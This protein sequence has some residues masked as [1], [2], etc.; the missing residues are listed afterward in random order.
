MARRR[1]SSVSRAWRPLGGLLG[2]AVGDASQSLG[3]LA[4]S[5][6]T[7][8]IT[9]FTFAAITNTLEDFPGLLLFIPAAIGLRGNVF[10]PLGS[11]LSTAIRTGTFAWS[12]RHDSLLGQNVIGAMAGSLAAAVGLAVVADVVANWLRSGSVAVIGLADFIVVSVFGGTIAS[13]AVL[14]ITIGLAVASVHFGWDLDNVTAPLVSASGDFV[15][16][17]ALVLATLLIRRGTLTL[18]LALGFATV[19]VILV[20][21]LVRSRLD[22]ARRIVIES[23]P[24][25]VFA[26]TLSLVAGVVLE[27]S[28]GRLV[29]F[30][31]LLVLLPGYLSTAGALGGILSS[32]LST[33]VHLGL[34]DPAPIPRGDARDDIRI[35]F[36]L[37]LPI[38]VLLAFL[39][40]TIGVAAGRTSPGLLTL[41][42]VAVT[43]GLVATTFVAAIAYYGT[44]LV[45]RFGLDPDNHGIPLV[46]ASLDVVGAITLVGA[47]LVW[48]VA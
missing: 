42:V 8:L 11:R 31:V 24:I 2:P 22:I 37:A 7:S 3:A 26:G 23:L 47:L 32:R 29:A 41:I 14:A 12:W 10:G 25:L 27:R 40:G 46:S 17:P 39:A 44:L 9:G 19:A 6:T 28:I 1:L 20:V 34:V 35:T 33:K 48:G 15:T 36:S 38:F 4:F 18:G 21:V 30:S 16:L 43:G 13:L 45:V 5:A